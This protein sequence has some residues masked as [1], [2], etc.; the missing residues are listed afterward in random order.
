M[1]DAHGEGRA[2]YLGRLARRAEGRNH[3]HDL[4]A[5]RRVPAARELKLP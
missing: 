2:H 3:P 5:D 1:A 4:R